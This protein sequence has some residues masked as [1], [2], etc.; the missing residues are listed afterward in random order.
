MVPCAACGEGAAVAAGPRTASAAPVS[1]V[2]GAEVS[3]L[4]SVARAGRPSEPVR[5]V[6]PRDGSTLDPASANG[7]A[8]RVQ[9]R[10]DVGSPGASLALSLDGARPRPVVSGV[11]TIG[12]LGDPGVT[13]AAG[14]HD[15]VLAAVASDGSVLAPSEG[16]I[17][18]ARFFVGTRA[19]PSPPRIVCL[20]P[21]GTYYGNAPRVTLDFVVAAGSSLDAEVAIAGAGVTRR[22]RTVGPGP[23]ALGDFAS[24]DHEVTLSPIGGGAVI[25]G[26]CSFTVNREIE[27]AP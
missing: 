8:V 19:V 3:A 26:R 17:A 5:I 10:V 2:R 12:D 9:G 13:L 6:E 25:P 22:A 16:G 7:L 11:V 18:S 21:F 1:E 14:A 24:G 27:R 15:L 20:T 23:F 4:P